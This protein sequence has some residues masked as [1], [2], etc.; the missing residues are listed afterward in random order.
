MAQLR[1]NGLDQIGSGEKLSGSGPAGGG[2]TMRRKN[3]AFFILGENV[4]RL[5]EP[6]L[7]FIHKD[8]YS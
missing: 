1:A 6:V 2:A 4:V 7:E 8:S 3:T 5:D